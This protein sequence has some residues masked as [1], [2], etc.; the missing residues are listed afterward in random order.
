MTS[1]VLSIA[2]GF[3]DHWQVAKE[4]GLWDI[5][6]NAHI[7]RGDFVYF[8]GSGQ[9]LAGF[10]GRATVVADIREIEIGENRPW[11]EDDPRLM[12]YTHRI[13]LT[14]FIDRTVPPQ[15]WAEVQRL[16]G[17][18]SAHLRPQT[19]D[20]AVEAVLETFIGVVE[21]PDEAVRDEQ[22]AG[23]V[24][25]EED[26]RARTLSE[27]VRREGQPGFR[28]ALDD[29]YG[30]CAITQTTTPSV[31]EAA[32]IRAYKGTHTNLITNGML[33]RRDV[34]RLFDSHLITVVIENDDYVVRADPDL[35]D[36]EYRKLDG[37]RLLCSTAGTGQAGAGAAR[38][39]RTR[40][41]MAQ[42][43]SHPAASSSSSP[44]TL[45]A[46]CL[47]ALIPILIGMAASR[48]TPRAAASCT[49]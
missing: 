48:S 33:L 47:R 20:P 30:R 13:F 27:S 1:W 17:L 39:P 18:A 49:R 10:L 25:F 40:M 44:P 26:A 14:D 11:S 21:E 32:H 24:D 19:G 42:V 35:E 22:V 15:R 23:L 34:H 5:T 3:H 38:E 37:K 31:L 46:G 28:K 29:A 43:M 6:R 36:E 2:Q 4:R 7:E 16:T 8:W 9:P 12:D 45:L 41:R